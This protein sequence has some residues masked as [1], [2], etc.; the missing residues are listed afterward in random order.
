MKTAKTSKR[1]LLCSVLSIALCLSMLIGTTFAWFTDTATTSVNQIKAGTL[2]VELFNEAGTAKL[3]KKLTWQ[4][5]AGATETTTLWEPGCTYKT[6]GFTI[7][8]NGTLALKYTVVVNGVEGDAGLLKV[9]KFSLVDSADNALANSGGHLSATQ[10]SGA[11]YLKAHMDE[12]AGNEYQGK[13]LDGVTIT[14]YATQYTEEYDST[15]NQYDA[16]ADMTPDNLDKMVTANVTETVVAGAATVLKNADSTVTATVPANAVAAGTELTLTVAPSTTPKVSVTSD[17]GV[18]AYNIDLVDKTGAKVTATAENPITVKLYVGE[19]LK[20][21]KLYHDGTEIAYT[22]YVNGYITF[23]TTSFSPFDVVYDAP[24]ATVDGIPYGDIKAAMAAGGD[25]LVPA[26]VETN[27]A[28][29][30]IEARISITKPSTLTLNGKI[31]TPDDMG[32]N[33]TNFTALLVD[34]NTT[35]NAGENGG[36]DT[37]VNG[38]YALNVRNS[39]TLTIN[40]GYYYGGGTAVQ[41]QKGTLLITGGTFACEPYSNPV[42]GYKYL[43]NCIDSAWKDGSAKIEITGGTFIN[44]DPSDSASE[45]PRGNFLKDGYTV[46]VTQHGDNTWYTVVP[47]TTTTID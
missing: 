38:G 45:N 19:G 39:A 17:K 26:D 5:A 6:Q 1:A 43:I 12:T 9:I 2:D 35:I 47:A 4:K 15:G 3:D 36:I 25:I 14:V 37:G 28:D 7:K 8:N 32:S 34:A 20:N 16:K 31:K 21:V 27:N 13:T 23:T 40:G 18:R 29:D 11:L 44:F 41:V 24:V 30:T 22:S 42:Y 10:T 46:E 33:N